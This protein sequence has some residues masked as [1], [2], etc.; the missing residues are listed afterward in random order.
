MAAATLAEAAIGDRAPD[1]L[2]PPGRGDRRVPL[3]V[4]VR[5]RPPHAQLAGRAGSAP[6]RR[7]RP[8]LARRGLRPALRVDRTAALWR[9][10]ALQV[11]ARAARP[12]LGRRGGWVL[13]DGRR[14]RG[15]GRPAQGVPRRRRSRATNSIAVAAL[16][17]VDAL[18]DDQRIRDAV[19]RTIA[20]ARP[21]LDAPSRRRWPTWWPRCPCGRPPRDRHHRR[22]TRPSGRGAPA[23]AARRPSWPGASPTTAPS[24]PDGPASPGGLRLPGSVCRTPAADTVTL[25]PS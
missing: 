16:L 3:V 2:R 1:A 10:R 9:A 13:H 6:G 4:H 11:A 20:L 5:R 8:R 25:P 17:R 19:E 21:L 12:V 7:R 23:L 24:S 14:R 15:A 18:T 22:P